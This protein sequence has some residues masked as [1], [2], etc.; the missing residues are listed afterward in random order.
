MDDYIQD[1]LD[2]ASEGMAGTAATPAGEHLFTVSDNPT[3]LEEPQ[4]ELFHCLTAKLLFLC[5]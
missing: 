1:L 2:E 3:Y 5:K 4:A